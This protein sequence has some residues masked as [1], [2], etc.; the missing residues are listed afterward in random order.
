LY[1]RNIKYDITAMKDLDGKPFEMPP[2]TTKS[3]GAATIITGMIDP[4]IKGRPLLLCA[5]AV[6][7]ADNSIIEYN[8]AF[9]H[10][11]AV[12]DDEL[13]SHILEKANW[14]KLWELSEKLVGEPFVV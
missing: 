9:L 5:L 11:N 14:V 6:R 4:R 13:H 12:A 2:W 1:H 3:E 7:T 8:G 10:D